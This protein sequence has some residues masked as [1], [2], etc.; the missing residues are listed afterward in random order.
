MLDNSSRPWVGWEVEV[1]PREHAMRTR[2]A[3][4]NRYGR[5]REK[6]VA[7][8]AGYTQLFGSAYTKVIGNGLEASAN[9]L[10]EWS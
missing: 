9:R 4:I 6:A 1:S 3:R 8:V 7:H 5:A 2:G 10:T